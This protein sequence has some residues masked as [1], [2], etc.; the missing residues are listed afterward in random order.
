MHAGGLQVGQWGA[1]PATA[2]LGPKARGGSHEIPSRLKALQFRHNSF[3]VV[4]LPCGPT[5]VCARIKFHAG[6]AKW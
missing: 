4:L 5:E 6:I 3:W 1:G 2:V